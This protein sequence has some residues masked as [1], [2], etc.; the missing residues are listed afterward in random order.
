MVVSMAVFMMI[1]TI[2]LTALRQSNFASSLFPSYAADVQSSELA[3]RALYDAV[4]YGKTR[5]VTPQRIHVDL[6]ATDSTVWPGEEFL[7]FELTASGQLQMSFSRQR[8]PI[9][10][11][12]KVTE[13]AFSILGAPA[14][15]DNQRGIIF[16]FKQEKQYVHWRFVSAQ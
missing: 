2:S 8:D 5:L 1:L 9:Q 6:S 7:V 11:L 14:D 3:H 16:S 10:L 4:S 12:D 13:A 15:P